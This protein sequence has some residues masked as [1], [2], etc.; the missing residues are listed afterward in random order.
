MA[1]NPQNFKQNPHNMNTT[2]IQVGIICLLL[3]LIMMIIP[4][5]PQSK[6]LTFLFS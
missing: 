1:T 2:T 4:T 5:N 3:P 6:S